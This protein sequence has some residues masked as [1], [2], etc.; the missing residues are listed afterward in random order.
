MHLGC[1]CRSNCPH[2]V[3]CRYSKSSW[4]HGSCLLLPRGYECDIIA[5]IAHLE[6][7][8]RWLCIVGMPGR[9]WPVG[10]DILWES[11]SVL[12]S[13]PSVLSPLPLSLQVTFFQIG[14]KI[15]AISLL[16][17]WQFSS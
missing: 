6:Q 11:G 15:L 8:E 10:G 7:I 14:Q 13:P 16:L 9:A 4:G 17:F 3:V 12:G 2:L 5:R 1:G